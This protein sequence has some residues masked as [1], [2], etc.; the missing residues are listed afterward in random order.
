LYLLIEN[1]GAHD[2]GY[3]DPYNNIYGYGMAKHS[4]GCMSSRLLLEDKCSAPHQAK[5]FLKILKIVNSK[6]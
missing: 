3:D 6:L 1:F 2:D 4:K 5:V